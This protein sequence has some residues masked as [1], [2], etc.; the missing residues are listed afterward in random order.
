MK[1]PDGIWNSTNI[2]K[3]LFQEAH[4]V[5]GEKP[6]YWVVVPTNETSSIKTTVLQNFDCPEGSFN[7]LPHELQQ[8]FARD[9]R[10]MLQANIHHDGVWIVGWTNPPS[11]AEVMRTDDANAWDRLMAIWLDEDGD[12]KF[13]FESEAMFIEMIQNGPTYYV[14]LCAQSWEAWDKAYGKQAMKS[15]FGVSDDQMIK[16]TLSTMH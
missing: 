3:R 14:G 6:H 5:P 13:S 10:E 8:A 16:R 15:D 4:F 11:A 12:P 1:L 7:I 2:R 9:L